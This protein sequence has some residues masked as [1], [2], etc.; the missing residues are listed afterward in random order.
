MKGG[1]G[2]DPELEAEAEL[3]GGGAAGVFCF[4]A[5]HW[6]IRCSVDDDGRLAVTEHGGKAE[7]GRA[8]GAGVLGLSS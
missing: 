7:G 1:S 5:G 8:M 3:G 4:G 2:G 6:L